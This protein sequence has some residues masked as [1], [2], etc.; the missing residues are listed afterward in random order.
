MSVVRDFHLTVVKKDSVMRL[1]NEVRQCTERSE[2]VH[3]NG[4]E[5]KTV[6]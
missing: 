2:S 5:S 3:L 6:E 4:S 1:V